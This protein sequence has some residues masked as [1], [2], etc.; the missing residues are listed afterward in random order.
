MGFVYSNASLLKLPHNIGCPAPS[1]AIDQTAG[2]GIVGHDQLDRTGDCF[3][4]LCIADDPADYGVWTM[5]ADLDTTHSGTHLFCSVSHILR[6]PNT[7]HIRCRM[8]KRHSHRR[9]ARVMSFPVTHDMQNP[10]AF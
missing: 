1:A 4:E 3:S 2:L 6:Y 8:S 9:S 10:R 5:A 7:S